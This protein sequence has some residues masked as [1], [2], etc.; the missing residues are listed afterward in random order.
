MLPLLAHS[1]RRGWRWSGSPRPTDA[2]SSLLP[3]AEWLISGF[4]TYLLHSLH[5]ASQ[6]L[7]LIQYLPSRVCAWQ[8]LLTTD[9]RC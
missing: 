1:R 2:A 7:A 9:T 5:D 8:L 6:L 4:F 3:A